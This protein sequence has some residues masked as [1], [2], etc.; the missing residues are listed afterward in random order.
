MRSVEIASFT[1]HDVCDDPATSGLQ[2]RGAL[3]FKHPRA[4]FRE[5]LDQIAAGTA[6]VH[7]LEQVDFQEA[8]RHVLITF[9]DGGSSNVYAADELKRRGWKGY[10]FVVTGRIGTP[11]FL[12]ADDI[13][14]LRDSGHVVGSHSHSHPDI[15]RDLSPKAMDEEWRSSCGALS[16]LLGAPCEVASV[17]GGDVSVQVFESAARCGIRHLFTSE[18]VL[19]PARHDGMWVLG[20][21]CLKR[22][23]RSRHVRDLASFRGWRKEQAIR[24]AKGVARVVLYP[25]YRYYVQWSTRPAE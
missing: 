8:T 5:H 11:G 21:A 9:D 12:T 16:A 17:P 4:A 15:F 22:H 3:P 6:P 19:A 10:F 25:A 18:P 13:R 23:T 7:T 20:R 2:R 14:H 24:R 1:F